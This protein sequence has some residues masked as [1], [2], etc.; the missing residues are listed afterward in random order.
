MPNVWSQLKPLL[1]LVVPFPESDTILNPP[2]VFARYWEAIGRLQAAK[3]SDSDDANTLL[4]VSKEIFNAEEER[5]TSIESRASVCLAASGIITTLVVG[6]IRGGLIPPAS[7]ASDGGWLRIVCQWAHVP[8]LLY[9]IGAATMAIRVH[10]GKSRFTLG[11]D[12]LVDA[13]ADGA[14]AFRRDTSHLLLRHT[15]G[16]YSVDNRDLEELSVAQQ[17]LRNAVVAV[18]IAMLLVT[19]PS[20]CAHSSIAT[21]SAAP[22]VGTP[23]SES[24]PGGTAVTPRPATSGSTTST[25]AS[26]QR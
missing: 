10:R 16:N 17:Y 4:D 20:V 6:A 18:V 9:L 7:P 8:A 26:E 11:P 25:P 21:S 1:K 22:C 5:R 24:G 2:E 15:V 3:A 14:A 12:E 19:S 23:P 13:W